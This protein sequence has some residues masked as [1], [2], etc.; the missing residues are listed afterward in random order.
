MK[1]I[2]SEQAVCLEPPG[3]A[4]AVVI[5]LHGLGADGHDFVP[6]VPWLK[7]PPQLAV[8]FIFPQAPVR[9]VTVNNGWPMRAWYDILSMGQGREIDEASL[10]QSVEQIGALVAEQIAGGIAPERIL[11]VGFSQGGAVAYQLGLSYPQGLAGVAALS[12][13][14]A[15]DPAPKLRREV[16]FSLWIA[17]GLVDDV[18]PYALGENALQRLQSLGFSPQWQS[19]P[20]AHEV[21]A[22]EITDLG[23]WINAR[24]DPNQL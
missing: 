14:L 17:H 19:Y 7:L 5:W 11:L 13:Y 20:M 21:C 24:L 8:R 1:L 22:D 18:V 15:T 9:P 23:L 16:D 2:E 12:T 4:D 10:Q 6:V 3:Q